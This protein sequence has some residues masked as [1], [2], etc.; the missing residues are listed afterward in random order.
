[1][2]SATELKSEHCVSVVPDAVICPYDGVQ[3]DCYAPQT[4]AQWHSGKSS[5]KQKAAE[6]DA[7]ERK[8]RGVMNGR[9]IFQQVR[10]NGQ[11]GAGFGS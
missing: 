6:Q 2:C 4:F 7:Q 1:M 5:A 9:E 3:H 10:A 11:E 8:R